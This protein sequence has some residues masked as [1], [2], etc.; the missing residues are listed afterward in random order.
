MTPTNS[1]TD[2]VVEEVALA[3]LDKAD[4]WSAYGVSPAD[5]RGIISAFLRAARQQ[6]WQMVQRDKVYILD[7]RFTN[8]CPLCGTDKDIRVD[9]YSVTPRL[10]HATCLSCGHKWHADPLHDS[11]RCKWESDG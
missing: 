9:S 3:M 11:P 6:G 2:A 4:E 7:R 5:A 1:A 10:W 8:H